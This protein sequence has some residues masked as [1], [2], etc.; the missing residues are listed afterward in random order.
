MVSELPLN[1]LGYMALNAPKKLERNWALS[2]QLDKVFDALNDYFMGLP[3]R[4]V[5]SLIDRLGIHSTAELYRL[6]LNIGGIRGKSQMI[7]K[8][9]GSTPV[10]NMPVIVPDAGED[11]KQELREIVTNASYGRFVWESGYSE[12]SPAYPS[13]TIALEPRFSLD[14]L[15][16][17][18]DY[19]YGFDSE[20][21]GL[22]QKICSS[23]PDKGESMLQKA[24]DGMSRYIARHAS[25]DAAQARV[26]AI[27]KF[28]YENWLNPIR[29]SNFSVADPKLMKPV[30]R[31]SLWLQRIQ[32]IEATIDAQFVILYYD[33]GVHVLKRSESGD[34]VVAVAEDAREKEIAR[35]ALGY[36]FGGKYAFSKTNPPFTS[37]S[38]GIS[39]LS[40]PGLDRALW[41]LLENMLKDMADSHSLG[42][43]VYMPIAVEDPWLVNFFSGLANRGKSFRSHKTA[44]WAQSLAVRLVPNRSA[45]EAASLLYGVVLENRKLVEQ[46]ERSM[47][48]DPALYATFLYHLGDKNVAEKLHSLLMEGHAKRAGLT[49]QRDLELRTQKLLSSIEVKSRVDETWLYA[50]RAAVA[51]EVKKLSSRT[52]LFH[53]SSKYP[54]SAFESAAKSVFSGNKMELERI[55]DYPGYNYG[56]DTKSPIYVQKYVHK[57][58]DVCPLIS[59][60]VESFRIVLSGVVISTRRETRIVR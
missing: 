34:I 44:S 51:E 18:F 26:A 4:S 10:A 15:L 52:P 3:D 39:N 20:T 41:H 59:P 2:N 49:K 55:K 12:S 57:L 35:I 42:L 38:K 33:L 50:I 31:K 47:Y 19:G 6:M 45:D 56:S 53:I 58:H 9:I 30:E 40:Q 46:P 22:L 25:L 43:N 28:V 36:G 29:G 48:A 17:Q 37:L 14:K 24:V 11:R 60:N 5:Y 23:L 27:Q 32:G 7:G 13:C 1:V 8:R 16:R 54:L 21:V